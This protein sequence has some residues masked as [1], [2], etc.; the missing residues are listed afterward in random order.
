[1]YEV[2][3]ERSELLCLDQPTAERLRDG[4]LRGEQA[5]RLGAHFRA[6]ADPTRLIVAAALAET[7]ELCVNDLSWVVER[8]ENLVSH[9]VRQL[10]T[11][12]LVGRRREGKMVL[13]KLNARGHELVGLALAASEAHAY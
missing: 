3:E 12:G 13:Y 6:L 8:P 5:D 7:G 10:H 1:M 4:R 2:G 9:H 11:A